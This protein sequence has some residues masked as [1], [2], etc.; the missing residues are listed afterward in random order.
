MYILN[1]LNIQYV[2]YYFPPGGSTD[3]GELPADTEFLHVGTPKVPIDMSSVLPEKYLT[4]SKLL[5]CTARLT[6]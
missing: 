1:V 5:K 3:G 6:H 2:V 4:H